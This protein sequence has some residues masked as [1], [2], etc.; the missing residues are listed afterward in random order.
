LGG[1]FHL[2]VFALATLSSLYLAASALDF[3]VASG[4]VS[5]VVFL[6]SGGSLSAPGDFEYCSDT[7]AN[8]F[9]TN[10]INDFVPGSIRKEKT[11]VA[12]GGGTVTS[13]C[14]GTVHIRSLDHG[15]VIECHDVLFLPTCSKKLLPASQ[16]V[17]KGC[18]LTYEN[19]I[20][21]LTDQQA[22]PVL[23]GEEFG[24]LYYF[25]CETVRG[26]TNHSPSPDVQA[27]VLFGLPVSKNISA[28]SVDFARKLLEAHWCYGHLHFDKLRKLF[29]LAKGNDP[30]CAVCTIAKQKQLALSDHA[31]TR[32]TRENHRMHMDVGYTAGKNYMF[33]FYVDDYHRVSYL[34]MLKSKSEVL[35]KWIELK[36]H[37]ENDSQPWKFAFIKSD[38]EPIYFTPAWEEH[39]A[40]TGMNHE[41]SNPYLHGQNG[42]VERAMQ[43]VG[44]SARDEDK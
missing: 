30:D 33:Q 40:E 14:T 15:L 41:S 4:T 12:V 25:H 28:K 8:R 29:G 23:S 37:L 32:S 20:V 17:S 42:V 3:P 26:W 24:G 43:T 44:G 2:L 21:T 5:P 10:D 31:H 6:N 19:G 36:N 9:V 7:G 11:V 38:N 27:T 35:P 39:C 34:D 22:R 1:G 13:T 16:F 18:K